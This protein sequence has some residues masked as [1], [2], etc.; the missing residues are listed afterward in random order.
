M[1]S[2]PPIEAIVSGVHPISAPSP[3]AVQ[4]IHN[5]IATKNNEALEH[6]TTSIWTDSNGHVVQINS[7]T[8]TVYDRF[9]NLKHIPPQSRGELF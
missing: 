5:V 4:N 1:S 7:D 6:I 2:V 8:L 9:A 3:V